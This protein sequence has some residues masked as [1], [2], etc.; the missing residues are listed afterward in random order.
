MFVPVCNDAG[1]VCVCLTAQWEAETINM[2]FMLRPQCP[3]RSMFSNWHN[4]LWA[5]SKTTSSSSPKKHYFS[6]DMLIE[7]DTRPMRFQS[8]RGRCALMTL[9]TR[10]E[11]RLETHETCS[12]SLKEAVNLQKRLFVHQEVK[13]NI[14]CFC[15]KHH[16]YCS[17]LGQC[18][19]SIVE[20]L[21]RVFINS[22]HLFL[23]L[24]FLFLYL[25]Q[26]ITV[27]F[28]TITEN[29]KIFTVKK[30]VFQ[31]VVST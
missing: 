11:I 17:D 7:R 2:G 27:F 29:Y 28:K 30:K 4:V 16:Y 12:V 18:Y 19:F 25:K 13:I 10:T 23:F 15:K 26:K 31:K 3:P 20:I 8:I 9:H 24:Y 5:N 21:F 14:I 6:E 1:Q 22:L